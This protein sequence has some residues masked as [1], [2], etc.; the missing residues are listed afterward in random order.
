MGDVKQPITAAD[1]LKALEERATRVCSASELPAQMGRRRIDFWTLD[2]AGANETVAYEIKVSRSDFKADSPEKQAF[3]LSISNRFF[4]VTTPGLISKDELPKWAGLQE[5]NGERFITRVNAPRRVMK[6]APSWSLMGA[7]IRSSTRVRRDI[8]AMTDELNALR[9][10]HAQ[11]E[12]NQ[13]AQWNWKE[14]AAQKLIE[15]GIDPY[16]DFQPLEQQ[17]EATP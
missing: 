2:P 15:L 7:L 13:E 16:S 1:I 10:L 11:K 4:Y 14:R 5:W 6:G 3:A 9:R 8:W 12:R 17:A